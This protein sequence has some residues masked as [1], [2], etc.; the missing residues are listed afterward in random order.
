MVIACPR[1]LI[2]IHCHHCSC[3]CIPAVEV[4]VVQGEIIDSDGN[5]YTNSMSLGPTAY[6]P[7]PY[8]Q[9]SL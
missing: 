3:R 1:L 8:C 7:V 4:R 2:W 9:M 6:E 5:F